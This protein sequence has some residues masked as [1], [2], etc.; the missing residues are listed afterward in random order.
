MKLRHSLLTLAVTAALFGGSPMVLA[1]DLVQPDGSNRSQQ[2]GSISGRVLNDSTGAVLP[3][4]VVRI[5]ELNRDLRASRDGS[6]YFNGV[7]A[8]SY[9]LVINYD[10]LDEQ[11]VPVTVVAGSSQRLDIRLSS[12]LFSGERM[13]VLGRAEGYASSIN[14]Q[15]HAQSVRTVVSADALGQIREGNIG[16][17]LVRLP[18]MSVETRAGVQRTATIRGL[19]P[20]YN[21]VTV[22][23]IRMTNVDGN[24]DIALDSFPANMLAR[25]DVVK[26]ATA[27][28]SADAIG[29]TV[30]LI[31]RSAF[32]QDDRILE[33]QLGT[34]FNDNRDSWNKQLGL[35]YGDTF[36]DNN[37]FGVLGSVY[38]FRDARGYDVVDAAYTVSANDEYF[39]NR[40][41][42]YDRD[43]KK[44]KIGA[45]LIF[46]YRPNANTSAFFRALYHYDYR[47]LWRRGT[48]YRPNP[49]TRFNQTADAASSL[50]GRIDSIVFYREPK[51]VF[52]MYSTGFQH[53][54]D[55]WVLD[56]RVVYSRA[57]KDYPV[58]LQVLNS[59]NGVDLSYERSDRTFPVFTVDNNIDLNDPSQLSFRQYQTNQVPRVENEWTFDTNLQ[60]DFYHGDLFYNLKAGVRVSLKDASQAQPDTIRYTGLTGVSAESLLESYQNSRFMSASNGR[61][62]LLPYFPDWRR[63]LAL[64]EQN[65]GNLTQNAAARFYTDST[66]ANA[67]FSIEEDIYATYLM[68]EMDFDRLHLV[69][70]ARYESTRI[71]SEAN[72]VLFE[73]N[74]ITAINRV[75]GKSSYNNFLPSIHARYYLLDNQLVLRGSV[76]K[77]ISRPP[78]GDLIPS[79]QENSQLNLR[80]IGNPDLR[81]AEAINYDLSAEYFL[82]PLGVLSAGVFYKD[83]DN[84]VFS[85]SRMASD[86]VEERTR[87]NG[88]GG[89]VRGAE[90]VWSQQFSFLPGLWRGLGVETNYTR[91]STEGSYPNRSGESLELASSPRYIFN[92]ILSYAY[93]PASV[94]LSMNKLPDRLL[95]VGGR[96]ALDRYDQGNTVWDLAMK[97][98]FLGDHYV[99]FNVKNLTNEPSVQFQGSRD[100]PTSTVYFG[101]QYNLGVHFTF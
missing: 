82:P 14:L 38:Y 7:P 42:Y 31:T 15:R 10:G 41:L 53:R 87:V 74:D 16:D 40:A 92:G 4:S 94:R 65:R 35:T 62:E 75:N 19:S 89:K 84:F 30:D 18:G 58:T 13:M 33:A 39:I 9:T 56:G 37:Q 48:D 55:D 71:A 3:S 26:S 5:S 72:E 70:G 93:G 60:R 101:T 24:R 20:Q 17:A 61:A 88:E 66:I 32:D 44:D 83:I 8:G 77:A 21:T 1:N 68:S 50:D 11:R 59:I 49:D 81:P 22:D 99:F 45:G 43:E 86:G 80:I 47:W 12:T 6:F 2:L 73:G 54:A 100:N 64:H 69:L 23:G 91:L 97:Y 36:G 52:Q 67:D 27:D 96:A 85:T 51:N 25:V 78:P 63:Y 29:G 98:Q 90:F 34:T 95:A 28:M 79:R 76:A 57:K 46:D